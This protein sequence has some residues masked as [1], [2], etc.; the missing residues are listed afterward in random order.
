ME[1][2]DFEDRDLSNKVTNF[3]ILWLSGI[4]SKEENQSVKKQPVP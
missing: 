2:Q 3:G 1:I 4:R